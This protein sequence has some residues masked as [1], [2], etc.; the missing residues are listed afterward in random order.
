MHDLRHRFAIN[1]LLRWYRGGLDVERHIFT[2][3]TYLGHG[4]VVDTYWY[5]SA[6]PELMGLARRRL[7]R[8]LGELP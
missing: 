6:A 5:L 3:S 1:T 7:E 4:R 8:S 2:L